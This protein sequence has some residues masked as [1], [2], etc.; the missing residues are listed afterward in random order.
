MYGI[1]LIDDDTELCAMVEEYFHGEG[2]SATSRHTG[3]EGMQ[4]IRDETWDLILLDVGL[5]DKSGFELL[6]ELRHITATPLLMLTGRGDTVDKVVG[7][8]MGADD[9]MAKPFNPRE[10]LARARA[11][12]R[13]S[14]MRQ[15]LPAQ[16]ES[17]HVVG[18]VTLSTRARTVQ[19]SGHPVQLTNVEFHILELLLE[20]AGNLVSRERISSYALNRE[21]SPFD[22][23]I[24]VHISNLRR[25]LGPSSR[26][27]TRIATIR[28]AGYIYVDCG[29][30]PAATPPS[31]CEPAAEGL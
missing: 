5:P 3:E 9:Y 30:D 25:K 12:I 27:E 4:A 20:S 28:G 24:D 19:V 7:L 26:M 15:N 10:L 31:S 29:P 18:D 22:R 8:E 11:L 14:R 23:S 2:M 21:L 1:L 16:T 6:A 17:D 13:R